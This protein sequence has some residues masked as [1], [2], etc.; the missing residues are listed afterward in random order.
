MSLSEKQLEGLLK[1]YDSGATGLAQDKADAQEAAEFCKPRK[2]NISTGPK[3]KARNKNIKK[4]TSYAEADM[5][6]WASGTQGTTMPRDGLWFNFSVADEESAE[7]R[8]HKEWLQHVDQEVLK[9]LM[10]SNMAEEIHEAIVDAGYANRCVVFLREGRK[11]SLFFDCRSPFEY[12][13]YGDADGDPD[14]AIAKVTRTA[15]EWDKE[16]DGKAGKVVAEAM[17]NEEF[18]KEI[19]FLH[20]VFPR[21]KRNPNIPGAL[22][23]PFAEVYAETSEKEVVFEAGF[24]RFP[25]LAMG[26]IKPISGPAQKSITEILQLNSMDRSVMRGAEK[27]IDPP[28][29]VQ[30]KSNVGPIR[31]GPSSVTYFDIINGERP[32]MV[33]TPVGDPGLAVD[34]MQR[35]ESIVDH[36]FCRAAFEM[37]EI[38]S[39]VTLGE[40]QMRKL[41]KARVMEPF[42]SR[43]FGRIP[44]PMLLIVFDILYRKGAIRPAPESMGG[45]ALEVV[46]TGPLV[47]AMKYGADVE[48]IDTMFER[49]AHLRD[50]TGDESVM[51]NLNPDKAMEHYAKMLNPPADVVATDKEKQ[52]KREGRAAAAQEQAGMEKAAMGADMMQKMAAAQGAMGNA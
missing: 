30:D 13:F 28:L 12:V 37:E 51:D 5:D 8:E 33:A 44:H 35:K 4:L 46:L 21:T 47:R 19:E 32:P 14:T 43:F 42:F 48:A 36:H 40:R 52:E 27:R 15:R 17:K 1:Q 2:A 16:F 22:N 10:D 34:L 38:R 31:N 11:K 3:S 49:G 25:F 20:A 24:N 7:I 26:V 6:I 41:E 9:A 29:A 23:M 18:E 39:G 50:L 45:D